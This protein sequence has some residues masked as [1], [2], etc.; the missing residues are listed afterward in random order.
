MAGEHSELDAFKRL[1]RKHA[2]YIWITA[3]VLVAS[4]IITILIAGPG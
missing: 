1:R 3:A 2:F 4:G